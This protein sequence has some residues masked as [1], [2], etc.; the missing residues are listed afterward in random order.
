VFEPHPKFAAA[1]ENRF[2]DNPKIITHALA[3]G[4]ADGTL[5][6]S[7][8]GDASSALTTRENA[9]LGKV[10]KASTF[11]ADM[12]PSVAL[13]KLNIEG[14]EYDLLPALDQ[15]DWLRHI[16]KLQIQFHIYSED[17]IARRDAIRRTLEKTHTCDWKYPFVWEQWSQR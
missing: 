12:T 7:D 15:A 2:V 3:L 1:I 16:G 6:L 4:T 5:N 10:Q 11:L 17:D 8:D 13:A 14:G 9:V